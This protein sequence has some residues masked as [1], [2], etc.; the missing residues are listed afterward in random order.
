MKQTSQWN[1]VSKYENFFFHLHL[2]CKTIFLCQHLL[3]CELENNLKYV[4][5]CLKRL[6]LLKAEGKVWGQ[7]MI[8]Q[9]QNGELVLTDLESRVRYYFLLHII[10]QSKFIFCLYFGFSSLYISLSS[11]TC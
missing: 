3:T 7:E 11:L 6:H 8:L 10:L 1:I 4:E 5:D 2:I 9:V